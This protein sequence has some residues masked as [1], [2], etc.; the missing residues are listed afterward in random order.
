MPQPFAQGELPVITEIRALRHYDR[1]AGIGHSGNT[2]LRSRL[3]V[4]RIGFSQANDGI[5]PYRQG[6]L[7]QC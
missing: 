4:V 6:L 7:S 3:I 5:C 1:G 2:P